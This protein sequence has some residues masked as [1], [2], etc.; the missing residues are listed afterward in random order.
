MCLEVTPDPVSMKP[1]CSRDECGWKHSSARLSEEQ[2]AGGQRK[3]GRRSFL[4]A[5]LPR[6]AA[7]VGK[8]LC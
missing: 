6:K 1:A 2:G 7:R 3:E 4:M 5:V 8:W